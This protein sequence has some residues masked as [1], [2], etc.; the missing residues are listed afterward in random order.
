MFVT[1]AYAQAG[2]A[3]AMDIF[4]GLLPI[5]LIIPIFY[6]LIIRPQQRRAKEHQNM[7]NAISR[8]DTVVTS[9]G[10]VGKVVR[11]KEDADIELEI[12]ENVRVKVVRGMIADV[13]SKPAPA[14]ENKN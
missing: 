6:F 9:G 4:S 10:I 14:N 12:A 11:V 7:L 1:P 3:G 8:G 5:L 13:R 2:G